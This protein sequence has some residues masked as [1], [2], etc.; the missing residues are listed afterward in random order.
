ME[1]KPS[2]DVMSTPPQHRSAGDSST[3][4]SSDQPQ[5]LEES[6]GEE[7]RLLVNGH[8]DQLNQADTEILTPSETHVLSIPGA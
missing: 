7:E 5:E 1:L 2:N 6:G 4:H 3:L 8:S